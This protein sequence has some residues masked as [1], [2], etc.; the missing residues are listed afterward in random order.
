MTSANQAEIIQLQIE[1]LERRLVVAEKMVKLRT[2]T[3]ERIADAR[4]TSDDP[5]VKLLATALYCEF[6]CGKDAVE[7]QCTEIK[8]KLEQLRRMLY[9]APAILRG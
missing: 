6:E 1:E 2:E 3:I 4:E 7:S 8:A 9:L 5:T